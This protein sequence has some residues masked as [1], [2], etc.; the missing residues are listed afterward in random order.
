MIVPG[1]LGDLQFSLRVPANCPR[2]FLPSRIPPLSGQ[3]KTCSPPKIPRFKLIPLSFLLGRAP[4]SPRVD[5]LI[6]YSIRNLPLSTFV[7]QGGTGAPSI[8]SQQ[9][10]ST[11]LGTAKAATNRHVE[12]PFASSPSPLFT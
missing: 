6:T 4:P 12:G 1:V 3:P 5:W 10:R 7:S 8:L 9:H 11:V 2:T